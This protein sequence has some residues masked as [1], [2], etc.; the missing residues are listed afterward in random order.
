M[1]WKTNCM[2]VILLFMIKRKKYKSKRVDWSLCLI[3]SQGIWK[4]NTLKI[5]HAMFLR[6]DRKDTI[7]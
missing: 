2:L 1:D 6:Y 7:L 5:K 3:Y 4:E